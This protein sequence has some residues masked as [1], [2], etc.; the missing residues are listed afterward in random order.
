M[1]F[2]F[3]FLIFLVW[4][5]YKQE[6][7][8]GNAVLNNQDE[9]RFFL[10]NSAIQNISLFMLVIYAFAY[11]FSVEHNILGWL[12]LACASAFM[13]RLKDWQYWELFGSKYVVQYYLALVSIILSYLFLSVALLFQ[14][15]LLPLAE[16][17][18]FAVTLFWLYISLLL[19]W[20]W[21]RKE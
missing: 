2:T 8:L 16:H 11:G 6:R 18:L 12:A 4:L 10:P 1:I 17:I 13:A 19:W 9:S 3:V 21:W 14:A 5:G 20:F 7:F 15:D